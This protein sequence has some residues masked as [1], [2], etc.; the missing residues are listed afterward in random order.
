MVQGGR[1]FK[2]G[3]AHVLDAKATANS[4]PKYIG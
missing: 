4:E 2:A 3:A 1:V